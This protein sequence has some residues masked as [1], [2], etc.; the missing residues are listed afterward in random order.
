M[1]LSFYA[2]SMGLC[3]GI[4]QCKLILFCF[5][6]VKETQSQK[7][8]VPPVNEVL[9][10]V[11]LFT[12]QHYQ[13]FSTGIAIDLKDR[14]RKG[15]KKRGWVEKWGSLHA[16]YCQDYAKKWLETTQRPPW[17]HMM[18]AWVVMDLSSYRLELALEDVGWNLGLGR[19]AVVDSQLF[20][21]LF[22]L[23]HHQNTI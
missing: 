11:F 22:T 4:T 19:N 14:L 10:R 21:C 6:L 12:P 23:F 13:L 9:A 17:K 3:C 15:K 8:Q 20:W 18:L 5:S 7:Q 16:I 2:D 1:S